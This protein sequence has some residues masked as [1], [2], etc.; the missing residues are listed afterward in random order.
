MKIIIS[1]ALGRMGREV[2]A[3][4][5][6]EGIEV[7]AGVDVFR[8]ETAFPLYQTLND[9]TETAD[10][11]IDFSL[12]AA[13][14]EILDYCGRTGTPAVLCTTGYTD[15]ENAMVDEAA[16]QLALFRSGNMSVGV[17]LVRALCKKAAQV[18]GDAADIEIIEAHHNR[19]VDAPSGTALMLRDAVQAGLDRPYATQFGRE[20]RSC[21]RTH[22]EIGMHSLRGGTVVGE[23]E[24]RFLC[25]SERITISH[26]AEN[27]G[28]FAS[29]ALKAAE[30]LCGKPAGLYSMDDIVGVN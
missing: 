29:G 25:N 23:H 27:R 28:L 26:S 12:P 3:R 16:K 2:A 9:V 1:G 22:D 7:A 14:P 10:V 13:L 6:A 11:L 15:A 5:G 30:F 20:G 24:V 4:A 21:R 18:L 19:K 8:G 17:A